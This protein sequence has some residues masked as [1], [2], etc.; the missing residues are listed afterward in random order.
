[1]GQEGTFGQGN[2]GQ[3]VQQGSGASP[4]YQN[5]QGGTVSNALPITQ[6]L[7]GAASGTQAQSQAQAQG[8]CPAS[9]PGLLPIEQCQGR[10]SNCWSVGQADVDCI[11]N[12][13]CCFDGCANV[14]QGAGSVSPAQP[15]TPARQPA[16]VQPPRQPQQGRQPQPQRPQAAAKPKPAAQPA[17]DPWP[18][19][20]PAAQPARPQRKPKPQRPKPQ[21]RPVQPAKDPWPQNQPARAPASR[22]ASRPANQGAASRPVKPASQEPFVMCPSA[23]KCVPKTNCDLKGVMTETAQSYSPEVELL[24]VPLIPCVNREAGNAVDVCCRDP[25]YKDPWPGGMMMMG[26]GGQGGQNGVKAQPARPQKQGQKK[27]QGKKRP[28]NFKKQGGQGSAGKKK[29]H[30]SSGQ[31]ACSSNADCPTGTPVCSEYGYC[32]CAAYVPGGPECWQM[33][34][35]W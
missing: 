13:L 21:P 24:R 32:Q 28:N 14:C 18:Q 29:G 10:T 1:M 31:G 22:P 34:A 4:N 30:A 2:Q 15:P 26:G 33:S 25:N 16:A 17:R 27:T 12:A 6:G 8:A 9:P 35:N 23:M 5:Q 19:N 7:A 11:N 3:A 20:Q